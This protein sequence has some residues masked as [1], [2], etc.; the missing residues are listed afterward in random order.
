MTNFFKKILSIF[1]LSLFFSNAYALDKEPFTQTRFDALQASGAVVLI[2]IYAPWC[3]TCKQQQKVFEQ[4]RAA[5]PNKKF[6]ILEVDYDKDKDVVRQFRAP[7]QST[8]LLYRGNKQH[9]FAVAET[10][11]EVISAEI[12]KAIDYNYN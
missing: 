3:P 12:N 7:R 8:L 9:W 10:R 6:T 11:F 5:N 1:A 4:F 2:D